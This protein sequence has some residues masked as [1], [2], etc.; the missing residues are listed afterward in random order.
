MLIVS[1]MLGDDCPIPVESTIRVS[2]HVLVGKVGVFCLIQQSR[3]TWL[4]C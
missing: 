3:G 2:W 4:S 1:S